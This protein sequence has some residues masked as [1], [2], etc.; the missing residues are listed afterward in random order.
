MNAPTRPVRRGRKTK[1]ESDLPQQ[2]DWRDIRNGMAPLAPLSDDQIE[3]IHLASLRLLEEYGIEVMSAPARALFAKAGAAVDETTQIVRVDREII[4][5]AVARAPSSFTLTPTNPARALTIGGN[6]IHFGLVS[7]APNAHDIRGG[8][9]SGNFEDYRKLMK[10]GQSFNVIHF[11]G[12]QTLAPND[13]PVNT[14]HLD[15]TFVNLTL[16]DKVFLSMSIGAGRVRDAARLTAIAR[17]LTMDQLAADPSSITNININSPRKLD[18]EMASAAM[19]SAGC[20]ALAPIAAAAAAAASAPTP[21]VATKPASRTGGGVDRGDIVGAP[22]PAAAA[23]SASI[24]FC[25][26]LLEARC[27]AAA[28][29]AAT[30]PTACRSSLSF[31]VGPSTTSCTSASGPSLAPRSR[32]RAYSCAI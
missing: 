4:G 18:T 3:S 25:S 13:L 5:T 31:F 12:N 15:T 20:A 32:S 24:R 28:S 7:G 29:P 30:P 17:G 21:M 2:I 14:R 22:V 23:V 8:R 19:A 9:R 26:S 1:P 27:N 16:T 10:L 11:F 6:N